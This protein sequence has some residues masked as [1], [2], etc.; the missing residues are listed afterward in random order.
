MDRGVCFVPGEEG[1][2]L[3]RVKFKLKVVNYSIFVKSC[4]LLF[5]GDNGGPAFARCSKHSF[6]HKAAMLAVAS[7]AWGPRVNGER[8]LNQ[9]WKKT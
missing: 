6:R 8:I 5:K 1:A 4:V 2:H 3:C 9:V 7:I